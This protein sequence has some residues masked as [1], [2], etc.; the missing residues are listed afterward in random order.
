MIYKKEDIKFET[1]SP[2]AFENL[3]Y[4][5]IIKYGYN[6]VIWR[7]GGADDG[8]DI[9]A[10]L[11]FNNAIKSKQ[12]KWF[13]ECKHYTKGVPPEHLFSKVAWADAENPDFLIIFCSSYISNNARTW[14]DKISM[15]KSYE[16]VVIEGEEIKE[17]LLNYPELVEIYFSNTRYEKLLTDIKDF[18]IKFNIEPSYEL[19]KEIITN[20]KP[21]K[22]DIHDI[23]FLL[24]SFHKQ[25]NDFYLRNDRYG[26][27]IPEIIDPLLQFV[28]NY[29]LK[30]DLKIF[31]NYNDNYDWLDGCG[32][33][34]EIENLHYS[35]KDEYDE[36]WDIKCLN[37]NHYVLHLNPKKSQDHWK[38]ADYLLIFY[39]DVAIEIFYLESYEIRVIKDFKIEDYKKLNIDLGDDFVKDFT[40]YKFKFC[41]CL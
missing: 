14:L 38:L 29:C 11:G 39:K 21:E 25:Y 7:K 37:F 20:I 6:D 36:E 1:I 22:L 2:R 34:F 19:I 23:C 4:D 31:K 26:D 35:Y 28:K 30:D 40:D 32:F 9:E 17:R 12:T 10:K 24:V 16:I 27:F 41:G 8:R 13:F 15:Y 3:C 33:M 18:K 5:L